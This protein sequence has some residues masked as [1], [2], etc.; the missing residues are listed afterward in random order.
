MTFDPEHSEQSIEDQMWPVLHAVDYLLLE[1][2]EP[3]AKEASLR[4]ELGD[5][6]LRLAL[7]IAKNR[8]LAMTLG[9]MLS[10]PDAFAIE[11][12]EEESDEGEE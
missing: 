7:Q 3:A 12:F 11:D 8:S 9:R 2:G 4:E 1:E 6:D 10:A 5:E